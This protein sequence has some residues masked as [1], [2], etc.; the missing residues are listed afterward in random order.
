MLLAGDVNIPLSQILNTSFTDFEIVEK[1]LRALQ[2]IVGEPAAH[3]ST[4]TNQSDFTHGKS[5][6][7]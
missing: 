3:F 2:K 6:F 7:K 4:G 5:V 1:V